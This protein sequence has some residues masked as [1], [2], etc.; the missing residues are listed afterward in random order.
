M[1]LPPLPPLRSL[2]LALA[3]PLLAPACGDDG[4][5]GETGAETGPPP[6]GTSEGSSST[7]A[8]SSSTGADT[9]TG[10]VD[11]TGSTAPASSDDGSTTGP[12]GD[13]AYPPPVGGACPDGTLPVNL[14]GTE[15]CAP[16]CDGLDDECPAAATGNAVGQCTPFAGA[17]GSGDPCDD[18]TP[19]PDG[20]TCNDDACAE[21]AFFACQLLCA[22]G[23]TC[24]DGMECSGIATCGYP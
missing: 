6:G 11:S 7:G 14:P 10:S 3:L 23:E 17:G 18:A 1:R 12:T 24:P 9:S 21:I 2:A 4:G 19:C 5:G 20:E 8:G 22:M 15:I 13:P 16:F